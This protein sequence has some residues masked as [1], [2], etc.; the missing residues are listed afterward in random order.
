M[1]NKQV[2]CTNLVYKYV[3]AVWYFNCISTL[4]NFN[5][6]SDFGFCSRFCSG[7]E[8]SVP[9]QTRF[10]NVKKKEKQLLLK[11]FVSSPCWLTTTCAAAP[12]SSL[13]DVFGEFIGLDHPKKQWQCSFIFQFPH[14]I[15]EWKRAQSPHGISSGRNAWRHVPPSASPKPTE[16]V[17]GWCKTHRKQLGIL[18]PA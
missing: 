1:E 6:K 3:F 13:V 12:T 17:L 18:C 14:L 9:L 4:F 16:D 15:C 2:L 11:Q 5:L 8:R 7:G 10:V